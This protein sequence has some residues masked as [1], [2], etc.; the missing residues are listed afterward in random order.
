MHLVISLLCITSHFDLFNP[1]PYLSPASSID[2]R[3]LFS[4]FVSVDTQTVIC[5]EYL[6]VVSALNSVLDQVLSVALVYV[7]EHDCHDNQ[8]EIR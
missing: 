1:S 5:V 4:V 8:K 7:A 2:A 3:G 6:V